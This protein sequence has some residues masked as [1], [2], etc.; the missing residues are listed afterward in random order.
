[1]RIFAAI[2]LMS[3]LSSVSY[4]NGF[5][6]K[7][8][9]FAHYDVLP[10][11][12]VARFIIIRQ[13]ASGETTRRED[14]VAG[15]GLFFAGGLALTYRSFEA[16]LDLGWKSN[17]VG[18]SDG[19][20]VFSRAPIDALAMLRYRMHGL[21][22]GIT[23]HLFVSYLCEVEGGCNGHYKFNDVG[24]VIAEYNYEIRERDVSFSMFVGVR[25]TMIRYNIPGFSHGVSG[26]T[27]GANIGVSF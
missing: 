11:E 16:R 2:L 21:G 7:K 14:V 10:G 1:M 9:A 18:G 13:E 12:T 4:A 8:F 23:R 25:Y 5:D 15:R 20:G 26:N 19:R 24:G 6:W 27:L 17:R 22:F 3:Q